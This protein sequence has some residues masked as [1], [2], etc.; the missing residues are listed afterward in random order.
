ME[1]RKKFATPNGTSQGSVVSP[2][3]SNI[4][5]NRFDHEMTNKGYRL[6]R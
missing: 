4:Y 2:L 5:L 6:T 1:S 3:F